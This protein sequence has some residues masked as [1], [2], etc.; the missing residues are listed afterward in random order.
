MIE[1]LAKIFCI[2]Q[3]KTIET[4]IEGVTMSWAMTPTRQFAWRYECE[5]CGKQKYEG[6]FVVPGDRKVSPQAY[7]ERGWPIDKDGNEL[8]IA[9]K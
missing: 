6:G 9:D 5:I 1:W 7:N 4:I 2:H 3:W 8:P